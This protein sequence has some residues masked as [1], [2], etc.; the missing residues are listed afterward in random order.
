IRQAL[1]S[2]ARW[3]LDN[4]MPDGGFVFVLDRAFEYGHPQL[5][6]EANAGAMFPT[7]FRTLSLAII[8]K[9]LPDHPLGR[10]PWGFVRCP[11]CQFW[12]EEPDRC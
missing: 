3:V 9:A 10:Y 8:G 4:R 7:W 1:A 6:G 2:A 5:R 12:N 11:G